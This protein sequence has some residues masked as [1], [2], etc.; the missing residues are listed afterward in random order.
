MKR[1][2][3]LLLSVL[4][5]ICSVPVNYTA[6]AEPATDDWLVDEMRAAEAKDAYM[7]RVNIEVLCMVNDIF[8]KGSNAGIKMPKVREPLLSGMKDIIAPL[9]IDFGL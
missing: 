8:A 1:I 5:L 4:L 2:L 3:S 7:T 9:P 6:L